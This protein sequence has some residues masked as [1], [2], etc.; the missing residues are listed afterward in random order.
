MFASDL[1]L[2]VRGP[3]S[4]GLDGGIVAE[5]LGLPLAVQMRPQGGL[6][7]ALDSGFGPLLRARGQLSAACDRVLD[8]YGLGGE[9]AA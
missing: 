1:R 9:E 2:V 5:T 3:G 4:S 8:A 7:E 6:T